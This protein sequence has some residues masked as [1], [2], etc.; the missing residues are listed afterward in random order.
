MFQQWGWCLVAEG[1]KQAGGGEG[2]G[3][4]V[5]KGWFLDTGGGGVMRGWRV[6]TSWVLDL[7][8]GDPGGWRGSG[9]SWT[10]CT[11]A[12]P[13]T[14]YHTFHRSKVQCPCPTW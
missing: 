4:E 2:R 10:L 14:N 9:M 11:L 1:D 3:M 7:D 8:G 5:K 6:S 12:S 13:H